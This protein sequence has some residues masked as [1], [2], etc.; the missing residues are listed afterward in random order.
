M[1]G[2]VR[3]FS[4]V[5]IMTAVFSLFP[6]SVMADEMSMPAHHD[7]MM[8]P[9]QQARV[10]EKAPDF[11]LD[12]VIGTESGKEFKKIGLADYRG[13]WLVLFFYPADF[14]FVCPTEIKGFNEALPKFKGLNADVAAVSTD[15]KWSHLAWI[16]RGDLGD[17]KYPLLADFNKDVARRY[18]V[19]EE[20]AGI[21]LR[22]LFII[23]PQ[24]VVQYEVIHNTDVGRS[25]DETMRVL[26][27]LQT[28]SRCPLGWKAGQ[29]TLGKGK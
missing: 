24:G 9:P 21:A 10:G 7:C 22:G 25:V 16:K 1:I 4:A 29:K 28:G 13:K 20:R 15:S 3:S 5:V 8:A 17:L 12:A 6:L 11:A 23:D 18:G 2:M 26:E 14:T 19:L 27:A